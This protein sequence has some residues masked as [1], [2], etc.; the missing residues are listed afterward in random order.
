MLRPG[1]LTADT[2]ALLHTPSRL[3]SGTSTDYALG[4]KM[5]TVNLAGSPTRVFSHRGSPIGGSTTLMTF[6]DLDLVVAATTNESH[7]TSIVP[8]ALR[9]AETFAKR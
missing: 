6:P 2:L 4:W 3:E 8:F 1:F 5:E 9:V 7:A